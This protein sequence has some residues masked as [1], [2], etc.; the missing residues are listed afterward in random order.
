MSNKQSMFFSDFH[1]KCTESV[2]PI[3]LFL[4]FMSS[5]CYRWPS[6]VLFFEMQKLEEEVQVTMRVKLARPDLASMITLN[7]RQQE[8][9]TLPVQC[10][11][12]YLHASTSCPTASGLNGKVL[13]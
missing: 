12:R 10:R 5:P 9:I 4:T 8:N 6:S 11:R 2:S 1:P 3:I 7:T 13:V